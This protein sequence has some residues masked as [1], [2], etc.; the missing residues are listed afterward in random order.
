M[1]FRRTLGFT[2]LAAALTVAAVA[3]PGAAGAPL[4]VAVASPSLPTAAAEARAGIV[5]LAAAPNGGSYAALR[6][7]GRPAFFGLVRLDRAGA[8]DPAFGDGGFTAP[9]ADPVNPPVSQ[10]P[11]ISGPEA[12]AVAVQSDEKILVAGALAWRAYVKED[13]YTL[14]I[15]RPLLVRYLPDGALDPSFGSGGWIT[16]GEGGGGVIHD[17]AVAP[18]GRILAAVGSDVR[19]NASA[20]APGIYAFS[21]DG[22]L[23]PSFGRDG[24]ALARRDGSAVADPRSIVLLPDGDILVTA[25]RNS[26]PVLAR[27]LPDGR[28][29]RSFGG[30]GFVRPDVPDP[31]CCARLPLAIGPEDR[32]TF[33]FA[34]GDRRQRVSVARVRPEGRADRSFGG[35]GLVTLPARFEDAF[36]LA[37]GGDGSVFVAGDARHRDKES[38]SFAYAV[39]HL[40]GGGG[41]DLSF[42][43]RGIQILVRG[44]AGIAGAALTLPDGILVGGSYQ[45]Q[46]TNDGTNPTALLLTQYPAE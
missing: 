24:R 38:S 39:A 30:D 21:G 18:D 32:P 9:F 41:P 35:D 8:P 5:D 13:G 15:L 22:S 29:D 2:A 40:D 27:L 42:G 43:H 31:R 33:A 37:V 10:G 3:S 14:E 12:E 46:A 20:G 28:L 44:I 26:R 6:G 45:S 23:D 34:T 17:L 25:Y 7:L 1:S 11:N 4:S 19:R 16:P 36:G